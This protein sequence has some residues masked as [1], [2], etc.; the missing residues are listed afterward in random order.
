MASGIVPTYRLKYGIATAYRCEFYRLITF[1]SGT[2]IA[3][4]HY[5]HKKGI[6]KLN[7]VSFL[8]SLHNKMA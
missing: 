7:K 2:G 5:L 8:E 1:G 3:E 4:I 6:V